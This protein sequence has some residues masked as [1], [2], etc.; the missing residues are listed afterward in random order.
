M[1]DVDALVGCGLSRDEAVALAPQVDEALQTDDALQA[2]RHISKQLLSP[3]QPFELHQLLHRAT[4]HN[5]SDGP[6]PTWVP[7]DAEIAASN[8][9]RVMNGDYVA[10]HRSSI[11]E[12]E[13]FWSAMLERLR[14]TLRTAPSGMLDASDGAAAACWLPGARL[15]IAESALEREPSD[16]AVLFADEGGDIQRRTIADVKAGAMRVAAA[17][18]AAGL[19]VG[20][21]IAIDM[22][23]TYESVL[24]YLGV[25]AFG[26]AV[27]SIADSFA[28]DE[29]ATRLRIA[30]ARAIFTQDVIVRGGKT[31]PLYQRVID[32]GAARAIV[33]PA[34]ESL[35]LPL[36]DGDLEWGAFLEAADGDATYAIADAQATTNI[37]F[38]SGTTGDPKAIPW[39]QVT[40]LK[41]ATDGWVHH[42][43]RAGDVVCWPTNL[44]WMMGPW[45]IYASLLNGA[46]MALYQG[47]PLTRGFGEFVRDTGVTMLGVVPSLVKTWKNSDCMSGLDWSAIRCFSSTG[48]A[49]NAAEMHWL[50]ARAGYS[51]VIE[52][53]GG[54]EIGGGY[55]CGT[56]VQPQ[57]PATF[58]TAAIGCDFV[59]LD[60]Q[61]HETDQG[62]LAL[63]PPMLGSSTRLLNRDHHEVYFAG[64]PAGP[65][66]EM[67]RRHGDQMERLGQG[68]L[69]AHG[70]VDDTMN[71][72]G[73]KTSSAE[74]ERACNRVEGIHETAAIAV[75]PAGGGPSQLVVYAVAKEGLS[76]E[77]VVADLKASF[78][79][80]I[81]STLNPLFKVHEV[82]LVDA[83][84]RT[85]SNKVMR[86]VLRKQYGV[87][88]T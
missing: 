29:I 38:S 16:L 70:R 69:R 42:D 57:A 53:C 8:V 20:D 59:V 5:W 55:I 28:A 61:G 63:R 39:T 4:F 11:D 82:V 30:E 12:P 67:L 6:A 60:E 62:E 45:L 13:S 65:N 84:P 1:I 26:G 83:L 19:N 18:K 80:S 74:I 51:P 64:M 71:L 23:M 58:S 21:A 72:G 68:Y 47:S 32:S 77:F 49:S 33:L 76:A 56:V 14:V 17:L 86:R 34:G 31:L 43:V 35:A 36:R 22:P 48:E 15:N 78:Q 3:S 87:P 81:R 52:Y 27:V 54:T 79:Q 10:F 40:P 7:S 25:V 46:A 37:L 50:M 9:G 24:I 2:W 75:S 88:S 41:S 66:G 85:A 73:I 44:G